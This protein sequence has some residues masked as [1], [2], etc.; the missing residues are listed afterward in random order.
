VKVKKLHEIHSKVD[1]NCASDRADI[2]TTPLLFHLCLSDQQTGQEKTHAVEIFFL[3]LLQNRENFFRS[4]Q[5]F[6]QYNV[7]DFIR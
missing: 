3:C 4:G 2:L 7:V 1:K 6:D 5:K